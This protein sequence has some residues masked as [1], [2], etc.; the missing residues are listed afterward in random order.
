VLFFSTRGG[1]GDLWVVP[2]A[3]GSAIR[4]TNDLLV[5]AEPSWAP[6]GQSVLFEQAETAPRISILPAT[7]GTARG[8]LAWDGTGLDELQISRDG[9]HILFSGVRGGNQDLWVMPTAGGEP[10]ALAPSPGRESE[11]HWS[12]DGTEV[13][14]TSDRGGTA[15]LWI[16]P[17]GGGEARRLTDWSPA[18]ENNPEWSPDGSTISFLSNRDAAVPEIWTVPAGGGTPTRLTTG[19]AVGSKAW[20]PD[21]KEIVYTGNGAG[22]AKGLFAVAS[23]GGVSRKLVPGEVGMVRPSPDGTQLAYI[24]LR[25]GWAFLETVPAGGGTP[26]RLTTATENVYQTSPQW[27]A[28]GSTIVVE[29]ADFVTNGQGLSVVTLPDGVWRRLPQPPDLYYLF[30]PRWIAGSGEVIH[31]EGDFTQRVVALPI[32]AVLAPRR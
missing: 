3:G 5:E 13:V 21:G 23:D 2:S 1:Q 20:S 30:Q 16:V 9:A 19:A 8:V 12:P 25:D 15:D 27:S 14:F 29:E 7:G 26:R 11:G 18:D 4:V 10:R 24:S 32:S 28:D 17:A 6:D 22:D 31:F